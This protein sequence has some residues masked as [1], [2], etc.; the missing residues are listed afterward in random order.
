MVAI[1]ILTMICV[2]VLVYF[3][4]CIYSHLVDSYKKQITWLQDEIYSYQNLVR[5]Y[6]NIIDKSG[7]G[8]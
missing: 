1:L 8:V 4:T 7:E 2:I 5:D 6:Q 3:I